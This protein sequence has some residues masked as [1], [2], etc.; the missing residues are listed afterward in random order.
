[1]TFLALAVALTAAG[2]SSSADEGSSGRPTAG[3]QAVT[4]SACMRDHGVKDFP[5]PDASGEL[6]IDG[7][8]NGSSLD[9]EAPAW[10]QAIAACKDLQPAGFTGR[11][12]TAE[13]QKPALAFAQC[14]RDHGVKDF[15]DPTEDSPLVDTN[16]IPSTNSEGGMAALNAAMDEC[17]ELAR[18]AIEGR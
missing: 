10:K 15:P 18:K 12:R 2:C 3:K 1:M 7:V 11:K 4:F 17:G 8:L 13:E 16:R 9:P 5:D 6:T 14:I